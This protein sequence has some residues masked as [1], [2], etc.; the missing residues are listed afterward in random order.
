MI[1]LL[2]SPILTAYGRWSF[3]GP[4]TVADA[5]E[6]LGAGPSKSAIGH[7]ASAEF[8]S[9]LLARPIVTQR[10]AIK[11]EPGDEA[12]VFR[13]LDRLPEGV[14]LTEAQLHAVRYELAWLRY[15]AN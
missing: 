11:M 7:V 6:R 1:Y 4:L 13:L 12:L 14:V 9:T 15:E 8:L 2:N 10:L 5:N 3:E